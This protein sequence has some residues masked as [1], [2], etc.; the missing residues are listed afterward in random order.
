MTNDGLSEYYLH[1]K[2]SYGHGEYNICIAIYKNSVLLFP[3]EFQDFLS[4][5]I[6]FLMFLKKMFVYIR[7]DIQY[8]HKLPEMLKI[9]LAIPFQE[10]SV[11]FLVCFSFFF[12]FYSSL[13]EPVREVRGI[14]A[15]STV[16]I[17]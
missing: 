10:G 11:S 2:N 16:T 15:N 8:L 1:L 12:L 6:F 4:E 5:K 9:R 17:W 14:C 3:C 13:A 7:E